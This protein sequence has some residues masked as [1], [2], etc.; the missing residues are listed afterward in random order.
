VRDQSLADL[1]VI[2]FYCRKPLVNIGPIKYVPNVLY[3]SERQV[4]ENFKTF[5]KYSRNYRNIFTIFYDVP[6]SRIIY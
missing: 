3:I 1:V 6:V 5:Q 2:T 4:T